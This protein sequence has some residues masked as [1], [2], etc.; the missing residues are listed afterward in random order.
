MLTSC[1][2]AFYKLN[3]YDGNLTNYHHMFESNLKRIN[4]LK[5]CKEAILIKSILTLDNSNTHEPNTI[6]TVTRIF[7]QLNSSSYRNPLAIS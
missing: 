7:D 2:V 3:I 4:L 1:E 6:E 5:L